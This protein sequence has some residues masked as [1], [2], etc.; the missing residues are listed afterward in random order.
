[1]TSRKTRERYNVQTLENGEISRKY[2]ENIRKNLER[3]S[4][5]NADPANNDVNSRWRLIKNVVTNSANQI[6]GMEKKQRK[7][8]W[9]NN[10]CSEAINKRILLRKKVLQNAFQE[11]I[12]IFEEQRRQTNTILRREKR[13]YEK[14]KIEEIE[15][16]KCSARKF[17]KESRSIKA[18]FKR[19]TRIL[20][21]QLGNLITEEKQIVNHFKEYFNHLLNQPIVEGDNETIYFYTAEPKIEIPQQEEINNIINNLKNNKAPGE[22]NIVAEL[23]KKGGMSIGREIKEIISTIWDTDIFPEDWS[24]SFL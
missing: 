20:S 7:K 4:L 23:L 5:E 21:D 19:Q 9:F 14:R 16:N 24:T 22:N 12:S 6:L 18:G 8:D 10:L 17:F 2:P 1:M 11:N 3:T 15:K 13:L